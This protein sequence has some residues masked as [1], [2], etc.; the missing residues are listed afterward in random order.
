[1][2]Y[3]IKF[4]ILKLLA[5]QKLQHKNQELTNENNELKKFIKESL[6]EKEVEPPL[7]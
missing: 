4:L 6:I 3:K 5:I 7:P 1:M 2:L